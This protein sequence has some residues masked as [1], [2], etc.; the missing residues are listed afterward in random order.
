MPQSESVSTESLSVE[1][2]DSES[3]RPQLTEYASPQ[4]TYEQRTVSVRLL[5]L[6]FRQSMRC[7]A[8]GLARPSSLTIEFRAY[9]RLVRVFSAP[10]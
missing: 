2:I 1:L 9:F 3:E 8:D 5:H 7:R 6:E 10:F 4:E